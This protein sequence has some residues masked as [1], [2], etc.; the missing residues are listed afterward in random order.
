MPGVPDNPSSCSHCR[1][2]CVRRRQRH[3]GSHPGHT[4]R[5]ETGS[6]GTGPWHSE[7]FPCGWSAGN[8][9]LCLVTGHPVRTGLYLWPLCGLWCGSC[10]GS[11][12]RGPWRS[13]AH[14]SVHRRSSGYRGFHLP[15]LFVLLAACCKYQEGQSNGCCRR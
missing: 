4:G 6:A 15:F 5:E 2:G 7:T 3:R 8:P 9:W 11:V 14:K 10:S 12:A 13:C 1:S